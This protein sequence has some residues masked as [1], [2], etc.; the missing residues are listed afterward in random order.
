MYIELGI[1]GF[2]IRKTI[3]GH[4]DGGE[5]KIRRINR[6]YLLIFMILIQIYD[7]KN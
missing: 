3:M 4:H 5:K 6:N 7:Q 2:K 1:T